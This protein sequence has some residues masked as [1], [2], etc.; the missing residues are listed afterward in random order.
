MT[1]VTL[2]VRGAADVLKVHPKTVLDLIERQEIKAARIGRSYVMLTR[3]VVG[4]VES[5][6]QQSV[7][8]RL[9]AAGATTRALKRGKS[10]AG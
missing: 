6:I 2:D 1:P 4:Y 9:A 7:L 3:D 8:E 5:K 10:R